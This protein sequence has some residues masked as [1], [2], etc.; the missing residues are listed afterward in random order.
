M[1]DPFSGL[2]VKHRTTLE[3]LKILHRHN[4][5]TI[6]STKSVLIVE[7]P[8]ASLLKAMNVLVRFSAAGVQ[9]E[10][11]RKLEVGC[12]EISEML[13]AV[14][15]LSKQG[16]AISLRIQPVIP[17]HERAALRLARRGARA[18]AKHISFEYL[19]IG[20]EGKEQTIKRVSDAIGADVWSAMERQGIVRVGRDYT[21]KA[22]AKSDFIK[23]AKQLCKQARVKFG[24]GDTEF[25]HLSDGTGCCNGSE[26]F[27]QGSTQFRS[28][29]VGILS[30]RRKGDKIY[31]SDLEQ[32]WQ[33]QRNVHRYL[34]TDSRGRSSNKKLSSWMSLLARRWNGGKS[35]YSPS[36]FFGIRWS[37]KL[38]NRGYKIYEVEDI[39]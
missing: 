27:L 35:P 11:R 22:T 12:P 25:I 26:Y 37:G 31:F 18:G 13:A 20:T 6:I 15:F 2:E 8:Y 32:H 19:K 39:F 24:A 7:E 14:K 1:Q 30:N 28:N 36:F 38:D 29:F 23:R 21:L 9:E 3:L 34:T 10:C 4:Y 5:P 16:T 33:P 17:G